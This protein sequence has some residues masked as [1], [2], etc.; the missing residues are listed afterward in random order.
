MW[1]GR[2]DNRGSR[3]KPASCTYPSPQ[4]KPV[5]SQWCPWHTKPS[6]G[7]HKQ[8]VGSRK[9]DVPS[10]RETG[11]HPCFSRSY[12]LIS[13]WGKSHLLVFFHSNDLLPHTH[14]ETIG[15]VHVFCLSHAQIHLPQRHRHH[16]MRHRLEKGQWS[17]DFVGIRL[18]GTWTELHPAATFC[19]NSDWSVPDPQTDE[20]G[21]RVPK[22]TCRPRLLRGLKFEAMRKRSH[23]L[24]VITVP[25]PLRVWRNNWR[26]YNSISKGRESDKDRIP[27][28]PSFHWSLRDYKKEVEEHLNSP[29][30]WKRFQA[31]TPGHKPE[32]RE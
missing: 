23:R 22:R 18:P 21:Q 20:K 2:E 29:P 1:R 28:A 26:R 9:G 25:K 30:C 7:S 4:N 12:Y 27:E 6:N 13:W 5:H 24:K 31:G 17:R 8:K 14:E 19:S 32:S 10:W 16:F 11:R 15:C 3:A